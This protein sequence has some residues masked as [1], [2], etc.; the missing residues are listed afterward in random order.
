MPAAGQVSCG[1]D[2]FFRRLAQPA[3]A[4]LTT[5]CPCSD[6]SAS[7]NPDPRKPRTV[8]A[9]CLRSPSAPDFLRYSGRK[10]LSHAPGLPCLHLR[11]GV[12]SFHNCTYRLI[13]FYISIPSSQSSPS[14]RFLP[15]SMSSSIESSTESDI[16]VAGAEPIFSS[17]PVA[18]CPKDGWLLAVTTLA[19]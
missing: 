10:P 11:S 12:C 1:T 18:S 19:P 6:R 15:E 5:G 3:P 16:P 8:R 4:A 17:V 2:L 9:F 7:P 13:S 14:S